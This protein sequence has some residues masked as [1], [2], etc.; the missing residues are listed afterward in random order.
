MLGLPKSTE[1]H[2]LLPKKA[3]YAK[4]QMNTIAKEKLDSDISR[5][6]IVNEVTPDKLN[7]V[8]GN[9]VKSFFVM[10]VILKKKEFNEKNI[11]TISKLIPQ[12][13]LLILEFDGLYKLATYHTKLMQTEWKQ[14]DELNIKLDGLN[15]DKIWENIIIQIGGVEVSDG[16]TLEE[17]IVQ[18]E[19]KRKLLK[20]I[21]QLEKKA[22]AERQSKKKFELVQ[23][24]KKLKNELG[25]C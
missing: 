24:I 22:R 20:E 19:K 25:E 3:I 11:I 5:I 23:K 12:N 21:E 1:L 2:K 6:T 7:V 10:H 17:Q 15:L 14:L 8:V 18:D 16:N 4:F 13:M 9:E